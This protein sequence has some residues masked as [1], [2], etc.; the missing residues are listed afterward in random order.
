MLLLLMLPVIACVATANRA[1]QRYAPSNLII[2]RVRQGRPCFWVAGALLAL[3]AVMLLAAA[4]CSEL[5]TRGGPG[6]LH[7]MFLITTW[8]AFKFSLIALG[9]IARRLLAPVDRWLLRRMRVPAS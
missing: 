1:L 5:A 4:T 3:A 8:D 6:W 2:T 7:L 9:V